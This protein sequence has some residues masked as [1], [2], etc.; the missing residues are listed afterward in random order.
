MYVSDAFATIVRSFRQVCAHCFTANEKL[1][2][3][4]ATKSK[5]HAA[6]LGI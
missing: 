5:A 2:F 1:I 4:G 6:H 3:Q